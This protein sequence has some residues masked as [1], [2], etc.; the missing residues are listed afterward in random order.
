MSRGINTDI[1]SDT[2][3]EQCHSCQLK[4]QPII[5][6]TSEYPRQLRQSS[7]NRPGLEYI[8]Q[9]IT[10]N[11][12]NDGYIHGLNYKHQPAIQNMQHPLLTYAHQSI[13]NMHI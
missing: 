6:D 2:Q 13:Q 8:Q 11:M 10:Q 5:Q 7:E 4:E 9:P 12:Q 1:G 3:Q